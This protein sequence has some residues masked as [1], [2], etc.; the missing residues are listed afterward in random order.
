M[1][2]IPK[3]IK[4]KVVLNFPEN[5]TTKDTNNIITL[6]ALQPSIIRKVYFL[7]YQTS[8]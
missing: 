1:I 8:K 2:K 6:I 4:N 7:L 3:R 5:A